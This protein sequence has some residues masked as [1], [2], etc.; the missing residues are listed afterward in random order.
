MQ[1][2]DMMAVFGESPSLSAGDWQ[3]FTLT[4]GIWEYWFKD[5]D[6][7]KPL[8]PKQYIGELILNETQVFIKIPK[9]LEEN[10]Q[11]IIHVQRTR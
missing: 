8:S 4:A 1:V 6:T 11:A 7:N 3:P 9:E 10:K 5:A 2:M